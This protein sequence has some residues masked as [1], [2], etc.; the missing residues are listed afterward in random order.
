MPELER[1]QR[2]MQ[3]V[4]THPTGAAD[5][6]ARAAAGV[7]LG[8]GA[9]GAECVVTRSRRLSAV[10][11]LAVYGNAYWARLAEC[12]R[13]EFPVLRHALG[14]DLFE[15]FSFDY[16]REHPS[17]SYTLNRLGAAF[18]SYL[19]PTRPQREIADGPPDWA[20][21]LVDL[22]TLERTIGEV[23]DGPGVEGRPPLQVDRLSALAPAE[24]SRLCLS[25][26][27]CLRLL[28]LRF[29]VHDYY[30]AVRRGGDPAVP[31]PAETYLA[32]SR[33]NYVVRRRALSPDEFA[34]LSALVDGHS[35]GTAIPWFAR[36]ARSCRPELES[37]VRNWFALW[38]AEG[39]FMECRLAADAESVVTG[40]SL[41]SE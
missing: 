12:L 29:P 35:L 33:W 13:E 3:A 11:R 37:A 26:S 6:A 10:E 32:V 14:D 16:L 25:P 17:G 39:Y 28:R 18:P 22:A 5:G 31:E 1:I 7:E 9:T 40:A 8:A 21:F 36:R 38:S 2:W 41:R 15:R 24:R 19:A 20:D 34:L 27:P 30:S 4:I 23:F